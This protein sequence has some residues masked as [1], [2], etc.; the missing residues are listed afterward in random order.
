MRTL[1][2][3]DEPLAREGMRLLLADHPDLEIVAEAGNGRDALAL[4]VRLKPD[5]ALV[6][7]QMPEMDGLE[8]AAS[9]PPDH[10]PIVIF[11]TAYDEHALRAFDVH[12]LDYLLKPL[13]ED[14]LAAALDRARA[15]HKLATVSALSEQLLAALSSLKVREPSARL[16]L[17]DGDRVV[18][19]PLEE[20]DWIEAADYYV[21]IHSGARS[22]L[23]RETLQRLEASLDPERFL[24]IHRSRLVNR[25]S[26]REIRS[27]GR[28]EMIV[29]LKGGVELK[30]ARSCRSRLQHLRS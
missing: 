18:F 2:V 27:L 6:D 24:R 9:L 20:I 1:I 16:A 8:M 26:I 28:S 12:A 19:L 21:E 30:V 17:R 23:H 14:R 5:L 10:P 13:D 29:V 3:D 11:V 25:D 15:Q 7:V 22:Y 4:A